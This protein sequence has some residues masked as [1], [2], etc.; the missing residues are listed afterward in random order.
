MNSEI[1]KMLPK[2]AEKNTPEFEIHAKISAG[3][4]NKKES[5]FGFLKPSAT[6]RPS[7]AHF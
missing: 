4:D 1:N 6:V 5:P 3:S 2:N 7:P